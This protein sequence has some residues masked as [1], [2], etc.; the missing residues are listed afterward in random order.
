LLDGDNTVWIR[1][2]ASSIGTSV[3]PVVTSRASDGLVVAGTHGNGAFSTRI[4]HNWQITG[5]KDVAKVPQFVA[6]LS[7]NPSNGPVTLSIMSSKAGSL[8]VSVLDMQGRTRWSKSGVQVGVSG[9]VRTEIPENGLPAGTYI[10]RIEG[11]TNALGSRTLRW[12]KVD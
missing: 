1:Q 8:K 12:V 10:V 11:T 9:E 4:T 6:T 2:G 3:V 5:V 7:P